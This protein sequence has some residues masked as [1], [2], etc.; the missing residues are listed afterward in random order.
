MW[1]LNLLEY[2]NHYVICNMLYRSFIDSFMYAS[3]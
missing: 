3:S 2:I 1:K